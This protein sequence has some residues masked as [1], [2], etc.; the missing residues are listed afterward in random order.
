MM[1]SRFFLKKYVANLAILMHSYSFVSTFTNSNQYYQSSQRGSKCPCS[2]SNAVRREKGNF[3]RVL[4]VRRGRYTNIPRSRGR[5]IGPCDRNNLQWVR[6]AWPPIAAATSIIFVWPP[7]NDCPHDAQLEP[8]QR[9]RTI[10]AHIVRV[11]AKKGLSLVLKKAIKVLVEK[12]GRASFSFDGIP[13][14]LNDRFERP[15]SVTQ[16]K[17]SAECRPDPQV[18][19][20]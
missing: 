3:R 13:G 14:N 9:R 8:I 18:Q 12:I 16:F 2:T 1:F 5:P 15:V 19:A 17:Q 10:T 11:S 7:S 20:V 4:V 6:R